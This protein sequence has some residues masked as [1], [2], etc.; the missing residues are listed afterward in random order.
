[1]NNSEYYKF[2]YLLAITY[3]VFGVIGLFCVLLN[4]PIF[5]SLT[6]VLIISVAT[7]LIISN[8]KFKK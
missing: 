6:L 5:L 4:F 3:L 1:M 8:K 7:V 2:G